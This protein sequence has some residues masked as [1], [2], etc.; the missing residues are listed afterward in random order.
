MLPLRF[1][2]SKSQLP[3]LMREKTFVLI[4]MNMITGK[5]YVLNTKKMVVGS[6]HFRYD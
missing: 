3:W 5:M 6:L 2:A 1:V 4:C